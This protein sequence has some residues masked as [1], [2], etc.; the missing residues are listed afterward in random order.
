MLAGEVRY[1]TGKPCIRGHISERFVS[2]KTCVACGCENIRR[3]KAENPEKA[4]AFKQA[5]DQRNLIK[6]AAV[7][8]AYYYANQAK[9]FAQ[10]KLR[11]LAKSQRTPAWADK[12][13]IEAI[14]V[15]ARRRREAGENVVVDHIYPLRGKTVSGLHVHTNLQIISARENQAKSN[16]LLERT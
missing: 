12:A 16:K 9:C 3:W 1:F 14:Y 13:A 15:E 5:S 2:T 7:R 4:K 11:Y 6:N 8:R 10:N